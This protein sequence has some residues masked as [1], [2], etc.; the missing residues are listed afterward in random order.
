ML[1]LFRMRR[2]NCTYKRNRRNRRKTRRHRRY[3]G[4]QR[5]PLTKP[6][7][8]MLVADDRDT[9][10]FRGDPTDPTVAPRAM[11]LRQAREMAME[12]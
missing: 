5:A 9:I 2:R 6:W 3:K 8:G 10:V 7:G 12:A 1:T 4:G 11:T